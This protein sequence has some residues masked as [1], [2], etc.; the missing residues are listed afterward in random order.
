M[1]EA[2]IIILVGV[3]F[4]VVAL[5]AVFIFVYLW[6]KRHNDFIAKATAIKNGMTLD[7]VLSVMGCS[8]TTAE[9]DGSRL[10]AVWEQSQWKG[11]QN[12]GTLVRSIKVVFEDGIVV[13]V[14]GKNLD[15]STFF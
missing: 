15:K 4:G 14:V 9:E 8:A 12:G 5:V 7:E 3:L 1:G 10:V 11:I 2:T 13:S 6:C